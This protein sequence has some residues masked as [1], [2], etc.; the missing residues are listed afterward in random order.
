MGS[1]GTGW[2]LI[3]F[4]RADALGRPQLLILNT[5]PLTRE[6]YTHALNL[7]VC[8]VETAGDGSSFFRG[9]ASFLYG[10]RYRASPHQRR[11][12]MG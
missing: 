7:E 5:D 8:Y 2:A 12:S 9:I 3:L 11:Q 4:D 6:L 1:R 10:P